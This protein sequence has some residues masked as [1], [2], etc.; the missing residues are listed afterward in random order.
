[1]PNN[2]KFAPST[3]IVTHRKRKCA[4]HPL[5]ILIFF[6]STGQ[7][8]AVSVND[9]IVAAVATALQVLCSFTSSKGFCKC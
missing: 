8:Q 9:F 5:D 2:L 4:I 7:G 6:S 1:M 3:E